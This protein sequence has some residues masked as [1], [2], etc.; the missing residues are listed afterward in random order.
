[1]VACVQGK[2]VEEVKNAVLDL[3]LLFAP[4]D[5]GGQTSVGDS[6]SARRAG[7]TVKVPVL[8]GSTF[9]EGGIFSDAALQAKSLKEWADV[10]Y[11]DNTTAAKAVVE[12]YAVGSS[13]DVATEEE[14]VKLLHSDFQFACTTTYDADM[15]AGIDM[16]KSL[17]TVLWCI[18][19]E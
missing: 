16:R 13:W 5:D 14:A 7:R 2:D 19:R 11:P 3:N 1:M 10:I 4:V 18:G 6:D 15:I 12:A 8:I 17:H 9:F